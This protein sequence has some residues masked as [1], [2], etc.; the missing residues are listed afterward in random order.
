MQAEDQQFTDTSGITVTERFFTFLHEYK[1]PD[2]SLDPH[3]H[4]HT[5]SGSSTGAAAGT[6]TTGSGITQTQ[7]LLSNYNE[8]I[9]N[10]IKND[11]TT[12]YINFEH[13]MDYD[14]E[15][16]EA[17][18]LE[19]YRFESFLRKAV[20]NY[21]SM[22]HH[23]YVHDV[24][25]GTRE[26]FVSIYNMPRVEKIRNL[27]TDR[28]GRLIAVSG[29]VTRSSEVRPE[30]LLGSFSCD[31]CATVHAGVEQQC[32]YTVPQVCRNTECPNPTT[33]QFDCLYDQSVFVDWQ[34]LRV[35]ENAD[36]IPAGSMPRCV[37]IILR[38][39]IVESAKAGDKVVFTGTLLVVPDVLGGSRIGENTTSGRTASSRGN[40]DGFNSGVTVSNEGLPSFMNIADILM[41]LFCRV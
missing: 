39:E 15:L 21:V 6:T 11:K 24:D 9:I 27:K 17:I 2:P 38:N 7:N 34:R 14:S 30:L 40:N 13:L 36:E 28:I 23:D 12:V 4:T 8:Q 19:Y 18:E 10:M 35:Q 1:H 31:K 29:T 22:E 16:A 3:T 41:Y 32:T 25:K 33:P 5:H 26:F 20:Q 37:D